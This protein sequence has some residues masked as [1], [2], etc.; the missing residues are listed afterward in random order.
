MGYNWQQQK[1]KKII[2]LITTIVCAAFYV[3]AQTASG[4]CKLPGTYDYVNVDYYESDGHLAVSNQSGMKITQL[5]ITVKCTISWEAKDYSTGEYKTESRTVTV[6]DK[7]FYD[8][9]ANQTTTLKE[10]VKS[11]KDISTG[12]SAC[13]FEYTVT[14]GNPICK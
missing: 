11:K 6:C 2:V 4:T 8:I 14:V 3:N 9:P 12:C 10:G 5:R 7:N 1:M 13:K